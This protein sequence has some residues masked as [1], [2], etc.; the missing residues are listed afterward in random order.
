MINWDIVILFAILEYL[1]WSAWLTKDGFFNNA[2]FAPHSII[3]ALQ[4]SYYRLF[5]SLN[6]EG[7]VMGIIA[8]FTHDQKDKREA[9]NGKG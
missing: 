5:Y 2:Y 8:M 7:E 4:Y 1:L 9:L 3:E 6:T